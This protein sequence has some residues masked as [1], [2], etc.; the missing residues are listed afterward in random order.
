MEEKKFIDKIEITHPQKIVYEKN[1]ITKLQIAKYYTDVA[2]RM[3]PF[4]GNRLISVVRCHCKV[5]KE[6]FFKKHPT[7][8]NLHIKKF[9]VDKKSGEEYFFLQNEKDIVYQTQ[10][11]TIEFHIRTSNIK[12]VN[13]PDILIF[14]LDPD[15]KVSLER[16]KKGVLF[17][18]KILGNLGFK[19]YLKT[20][21]GKGYHIFV[22]FKASCS[23]EKCE[24][25]AKQISIL[26]EKE[27][28]DLFTTNIRKKN[29]K[30]K[31]FVDYLRNSKGATC[32]APYSL[33]AREG[34]SISFPIS[35]RD[36][37]NISP[38]EIT[39]SNYKK[40]LKKANPWKDFFDFEQ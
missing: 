7:T 31:I 39:I 16:L 36:L 2:K 8:E 28:S 9:V 35:W 19:S 4:V 5:G 38:N 33:R 14:D 13:K 26:L 24:N 1:K 17:V 6:C 3:F 10:M 34:A 37:K 40:Y 21:G 15:S 30:N 29:R 25:F 23:F 27:Y 12:S 11:G 18:K 32:V 22:P 20:S